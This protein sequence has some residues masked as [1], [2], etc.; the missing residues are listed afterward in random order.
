MLC[1]GAL[2][3]HWGIYRISSLVFPFHIGENTQC[4][5]NLLDNQHLKSMPH[6]NHIITENMTLV[7]LRLILSPC[8]HQNFTAL[9]VKDYIKYMKVNMEIVSYRCWY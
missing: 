5:M 2:R 6:T 9:Q 3:P 4:L 1:L 7:A 8:L